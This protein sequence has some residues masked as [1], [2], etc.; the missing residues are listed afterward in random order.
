MQL[1]SVVIKNMDSLRYLY[2]IIRIY[3]AS[4][5]TSG[6]M[7]IPVQ[8]ILQVD[9]NKLTLLSTPQKTQFISI[10]AITTTSGLDTHLYSIY[11]YLYL[12]IY[13]SFRYK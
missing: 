1:K 2:G 11:L 9:T 13:L 8:G 6:D 7:L 10:R 4:V 3:S 5:T 12:S